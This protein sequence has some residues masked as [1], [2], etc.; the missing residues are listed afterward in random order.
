MTEDVNSAPEQAAEPVD[1]AS[2]AAPIPAA[3]EVV[4]ASGTLPDPS[5]PAIIGTYQAPNPGAQPGEVS[6]QPL[7][8]GSAADPDPQA[9]VDA[10]AAA[11]AQAA[12]DPVAGTADDPNPEASAGGSTEPALAGPGATKHARRGVQAGPAD[13]PRSHHTHH[14]A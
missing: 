9:T 11:A 12:P 3:P 10:A 8:A 7:V 6:E 4:P 2:L 5:D 13:H 14:H 1:D